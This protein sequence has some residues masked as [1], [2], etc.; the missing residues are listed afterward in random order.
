MASSASTS[1]VPYCT[2][3]QQLDHEWRKCTN[4]CYWCKGM[5][6]GLPCAAQAGLYKDIDHRELDRGRMANKT[7]LDRDIEEITKQIKALEADVPAYKTAK[8]M[9]ERGHVTRDPPQVPPSQPSGPTPAEGACLV[10]LAGSAEAARGKVWADLVPGYAT[11]GNAN[12]KQKWRSRLNKQA[13]GEHKMP[14]QGILQRALAH[15]GKWPLPAGS[16][17]RVWQGANEDDADFYK[18]NPNV[19]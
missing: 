1:N 9:A 8:R 15:N 13:T 16:P 3:C 10:L 19:S 12:Q 4:R 2:T 14:E 5:H 11:L 7:E 6:A 18:N 17:I